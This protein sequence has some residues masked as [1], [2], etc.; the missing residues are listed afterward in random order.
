MK[1]EGR[2]QAPGTGP[3]QP[4]PA[5]ALPRYTPGE[6]R[7]E[8]QF[9]DLNNYGRSLG[10][11]VIN[12]FVG[13]KIETP[14]GDVLIDTEM[15]S[16]SFV[17]NFYDYIF[18]AI[19]SYIDPFVGA[20]NASLS[21]TSWGAGL[22]R[23][24][25]TS[26]PLNTLALN[27]DTLP[28]SL[29]RLK[30]SLGGA[31]STTSG[32]IAGSSAAVESFDSGDLSALIANGLGAGQ[33]SYGAQAATTFSYNS[34]NKTA[35]AVWARALTNSSGGLITVREVG[36]YWLIAFQA[37]GNQGTFLFVRDVLSPEVTVP[38]LAVITITYRTQLVYPD[39]VDAPMYDG[40]VGYWEAKGA[41][42]QWQRWQELQGWG[43]MGYV[44]QRP[45]YKPQ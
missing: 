34:Q 35:T 16:R 8:W 29:T 40:P 32:I 36:V 27:Y 6:T 38:N 39:P 44:P 15:R 7:P 19:T 18:G 31:G 43:G 2:I 14:E 37:G 30:I 10:I 1:I 22:L 45:R 12:A 11:P 28:A 26:S 24:R 13:V 5:P 42:L 17:R 3:F 25:A 20:N 21:A 33:L 41:R 9:E 4:H 23:L